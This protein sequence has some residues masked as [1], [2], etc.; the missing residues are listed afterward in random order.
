[1]EELQPKPQSKLSSK[2]FV[3]LKKFPFSM[4]MEKKKDPLSQVPSKEWREEIFLLIW[5]ELPQY[6][7]L[8]NKFQEK[9]LN[10]EKESEL[11]YT[12]LKTLQEEHSLDFQDLIQNS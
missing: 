6:F 1:M 7:L 5:E 8:K 9:D 10:Q 11:F 2:K 12:K 3:R 4:N